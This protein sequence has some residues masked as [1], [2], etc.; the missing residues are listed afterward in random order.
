MTYKV[1]QWAT[2]AMGKTCLRAI[3]DHP[4]LELAGLYVYGEKKA[5]RDAGDIAYR[6]ET[7]VIATRDIAD[8]LAI[9]ADIVIHAARL[10]PPYDHHYGDIIR[11]LESGKNVVSINGN[12]FPAYWPEAR[13]RKFEAACVKGGASF[14]GAGLN[15]GFAAERLLAA[16]L[17]MTLAPKSAKLSEIVITRD[18]KSPQYVFDILGF[19][20]MPGDVDPNSPDW[21]PA[22]TLNDMFSETVAAMADRLGVVPDEIV[23]DHAM[24]P[25]R[26]DM[27]IAAGTIPKGGASHFDWRWKALKDGEPVATVHVIWAMDKSYIPNDEPLWRLSIDGTPKVDLAIEL[28]PPKERDGRTSA[29]QLG[30]A[31]TVLNAIPRIVNAPPGPVAATGDSVAPLDKK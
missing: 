21:V 12:S 30:V 31:A 1:I 13:R 28:E 19:G 22:Q 6:D 16:A 8:I 14:G 2:G 29:E 26:D 3:I 24:R 15:P 4:D 20:S 17:E 11:L 10:Q 27:E 5:G 9:D 18:V 23:T 7:G 25:A